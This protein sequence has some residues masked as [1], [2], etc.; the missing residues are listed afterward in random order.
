MNVQELAAQ[1]RDTY[2][3]SPLLTESAVENMMLRQFE[4]LSPN[5]KLDRL[6]ELIRYF[7]PP[8]DDMGVQELLKLFSRLLDRP[9]TAAD[10]SSEELIERIAGSLQMI[11][12]EL[13]EI[14]H[15]IK[16]SAISD[17]REDK[18][19][20]IMIEDILQNEHYSDKLEDHLRQIK[21]ALIN[22]HRAYK[23]A[24]RAVADKIISGFDPAAIRSAA[25]KFGLF[26]KMHEKRF[27]DCQN[28]AQSDQFMVEFIRQFEIN[29]QQLTKEESK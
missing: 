28:W 3:T 18:T 12:R 14:L 22:S 25:G 26:Q 20:R 21:T 7:A 23:K 9:L 2:Q 4:S 19:I 8:P 10:L 5:E 15:N 11:F 17:D 13:N 24:A 6:D 29:Y 27:N 1:I 16:Q